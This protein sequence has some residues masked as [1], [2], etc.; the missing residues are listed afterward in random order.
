MS[1]A[2]L[3]D[4]ASEPGIGACF[5]L[6]CQAT[7][8]KAATARPLPPATRDAARDSLSCDVAL[9]QKAQ[10]VEDD[11]QARAHVGEHGHPQRRLAKYSQDEE[12]RF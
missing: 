9:P 2:G 8:V 11:E 12:D 4:G 1:E 3:R 10:A 7:S 5:V 6:S